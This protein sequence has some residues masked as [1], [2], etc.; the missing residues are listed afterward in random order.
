MTYL[1]IYK[2][3]WAAI[4]AFLLILI[5]PMHHRQPAL[6]IDL[7]A[8]QQNRVPGLTPVGHCIPNDVITVMDEY[9]RYCE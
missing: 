9:E 7:K 2:I 8:L 5:W 3:T 6:N 1:T 4:A